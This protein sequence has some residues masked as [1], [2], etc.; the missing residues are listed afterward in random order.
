MPR[1]ILIDDEPPARDILRALLAAHPDVVVTAEAGTLASARE[2]LGRNDYDLVFLDI[3]LRGGTG[4]D[5]VD[6]VRP[7][8]RIIFVTAY[9]RHALRAFEVNAL[10]YL[11]KP[12]DPARLSQAL[13]RL[14]LPAGPAPAGPLGPEDRLFLKLGSGHERLVRLAEIRL[15]CS[16]ENYSEIALGDGKRLLVRKTMK[17]WEELLPATQFVRI[18]RQTIV[19]LAHL[20]RIERASEATSL[21]YLDGAAEPVVASYRYLPALREQLARRSA[22]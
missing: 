4:F 1:A 17:A 6:H 3:Q 13:A 5:L 11:L 15:V 10:D 19:N 18:H 7:G 9:D 12:I 14:I 2:V 22:R 8:T 16:C 20:A 21:V